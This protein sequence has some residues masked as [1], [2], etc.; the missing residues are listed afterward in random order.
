MFRMY[1]ARWHRQQH[2]RLVGLV[3]DYLETLDHD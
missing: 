1:R 3:G 2:E